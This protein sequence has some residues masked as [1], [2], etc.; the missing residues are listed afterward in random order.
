MTPPSYVQFGVYIRHPII[1]VVPY[2]VFESSHNLLVD[3]ILKDLLA[4]CLSTAPC[5][6]AQRRCAI[7]K[8]QF[9]PIIV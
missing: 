7:S 9:F 1:L 5:L 8:E 2:L 3:F 6:M 4:H